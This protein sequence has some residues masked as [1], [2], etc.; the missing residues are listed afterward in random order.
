MVKLKVEFESP[1]KLMFTCEWSPM[2]EIGNEETLVALDGGFEGPSD[3]LE[4]S[5][6]NAPVTC[7]SESKSEL[8]V[9]NVDS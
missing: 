3:L 1:D 2:G 8:N 7:A 9:R 6:D 5:F 4:M